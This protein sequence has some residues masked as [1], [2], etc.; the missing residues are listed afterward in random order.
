[1]GKRL[2]RVCDHLFW[3]VNEN[4][5]LKDLTWEMQKELGRIMSL[6]E[7]D[8]SPPKCHIINIWDSLHNFARKT[9]ER[10]L[11][12]WMSVNLDIWE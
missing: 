4:T 12:K 1:M 6:W 2:E 8:L 10:E 11:K 9:G 7:D 3:D 5:V